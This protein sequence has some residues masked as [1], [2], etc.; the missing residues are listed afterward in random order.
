MKGNVLHGGSGTRLR[1]L[2][3]KG[4]KQ[5]IPIADK[6]VSQYAVEDLLGCGIKEI[7]QITVNVYYYT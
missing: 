7:A 5:L 6:P 3:D 4:P 1:P 2:T